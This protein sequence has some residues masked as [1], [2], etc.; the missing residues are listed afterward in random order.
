MC[1]NA[2]LR[3]T[4]IITEGCLRGTRC[5]GIRDIAHC[6]LASYLD[7]RFQH[8]QRFNT[9]N[10]FTPGTPKSVTPK[11]VTPNARDPEIRHP[12]RSGSRKPRTPNVRGNLR[13]QRR[14]VKLP[15][16]VRISEF[17]DLESSRTRNALNKLIYL[18]LRCSLQNYDRSVTV[19]VHE[20][21]SPC[22]TP[23][24]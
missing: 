2:G 8:M 1:R 15:S 14:P 21:K 23:G 9:C 12:E 24:T 6:T 22:Q 11:S 20:K 16:G 18:R 4:V 10:G 19:R 5:T 13:R 17:D 7:G 3:L